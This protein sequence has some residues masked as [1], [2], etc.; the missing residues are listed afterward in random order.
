MKRKASYFVRVKK[1]VCGQ[2][3]H[4]SVIF[5]VKD[6]ADVDDVRD[7][8]P[9]TVNDTSNLMVNTLGMVRAAVTPTHVGQSVEL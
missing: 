2:S 9:G 1:L 5:G 8:Q 4:A 6:E 7:G 3:D